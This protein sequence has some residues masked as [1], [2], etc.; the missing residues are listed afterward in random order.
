MASSHLKTQGAWASF[1]RNQHFII[2][3]LGNESPQRNKKC[4]VCPVLELCLTGAISQSHILICF[5][6][7]TG[8]GLMHPHIHILSPESESFQ[9]KNTGEDFLKGLKWKYMTKIKKIMKENSFNKFKLTWCIRT[10]G[11]SNA[12][13]LMLFYTQLRFTFKSF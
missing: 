13:L 12:V 6:G 2:F 8:N 5:L 11:N 1:H 9:N 7:F 4:L 3:R 10:L